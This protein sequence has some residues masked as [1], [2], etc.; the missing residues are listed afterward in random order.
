MGNRGINKN[1][2]VG[3]EYGKRGAPNCKW[4]RGRGIWERLKII[5]KREIN[6]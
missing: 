5:M 2:G 3:M 1:E 6:E 4:G